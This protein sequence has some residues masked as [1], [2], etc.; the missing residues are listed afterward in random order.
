MNKRSLLTS[1]FI[2]TLV[3]I[4]LVA[5][6]NAARVA[7]ADT[8]EL[9]QTRTEAKH[10]SAPATYE[11]KDNTITIELSEYAGYAGLIVANGGLDPS[12]NSTFF[13]DYGFKVR[14]T[15][16]EE[17]SWPALN[18]GKMAASVT[19]VDVLAAYGKQFQV[20]IPAQIGFSRGADGI[21]VRSDIKKINDL[22]G[23]VVV[24]SQFTESDFFI[25]YLA[26]E[27]NIPVGTLPDLDAK[28]DPDKINL[29]YCDDG[30]GA[31]DFF[32]ADMAGGKN[33]LAGC[34]T[35][36]PK[37]AEVAQQSNG[38]AH[39]LVTNKNLLTIAD[40]IVVNKGFAAEHPDMV[41]GIVAGLLDGNRKVNETPDACYPTIAAAFKWDVDKA[42][43]ELAKVHLANFP[44]NMAFF[45]GEMDASGSYSYIYQ[46]AAFAYQ[47]FV[48]DP[49]SESDFLDLSYLKAL[50][51][52]GRY[53]D[54]K[55]EIKP[56]GSQDAAKSEE[57]VLTKDIRFQFEPNSAILD[58]ADPENAK[59]LQQIAQL[60]IVSP[61]S[62]I[63]LTGHVDDKLKSYFLQMGGESRLRMQSLVSQKLS[64]DR[65]NTIKR[66]LTSKYGVDD[67]RIAAEGKGW[68]QPLVPNGSD[69]NRRVEVSWFTVE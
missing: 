67:Q 22:R 50:D 24:S 33:K 48:K 44:E 2:A 29:V 30:F 62:T 68:N 46:S 21:V 16:S 65:A 34:V 19:T 4:L 43:S 8:V 55:V 54:E 45:S 60:L 32:A 63:L 17:E 20:I 13:K 15:L 57:P 3:A 26:E 9:S 27:A 39:V 47:D 12:E 10:L 53:S 1:R 31:G 14:L 41:K 6:P 49:A 35:W 42:K 59:K 64:E 11:P 28:P 56:I 7:R 51:K 61:G 38:K 40:I 25:R 69:K 23:K 18:S 37:T 52:T 5:V 36:D 66:L 58:A